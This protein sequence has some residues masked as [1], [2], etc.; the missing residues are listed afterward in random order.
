MRHLVLLINLFLI[1]SASA[2]ELIGWNI[3]W[4]VNRRRAHEF[5]DSHIGVD[6]DLGWMFSGSRAKVKTYYAGVKPEFALSRKVSVDAGLRISYS[7]SSVIYS[8]SSVNW[9]MDSENYIALS[10][11]NQHSFYM[12]VPFDLRFMPC[13]WD[14]S[15]PYIKAGFGVNFRLGVKSDL[16]AK[17]DEMRCYES[18]MEKQVEKPDFVAIP[19]W[20]GVGGQ[21]GYDNAFCVELTFPYIMDYSQ[22]SSLVK[23]S[24]T[25]LGIQ[26]MYRIPVKKH[27]EE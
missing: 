25:G 6:S 3:E 9:H 15:G 17:D 23:L 24:G 12:G 18:R 19:M 16:T 7:H 2:Q 1:S 10:E 20:M 4:G 27:G 14:D 13:D 21:F 5:K 11:M 22:M 26:F 8:N